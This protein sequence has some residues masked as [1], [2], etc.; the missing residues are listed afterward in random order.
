MFATPP[1]NSVQATYNEESE[2]SED[3]TVSESPLS[4]ESLSTFTPGSMYLI[5]GELIID[6][7]PKDSMDFCSTD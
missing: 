4:Y 5:D 1:S 3:N 7:D 2:T 6:T